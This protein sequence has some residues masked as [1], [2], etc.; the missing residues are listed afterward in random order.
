MCSTDA[1]RNWFIA[2]LVALG[3]AISSVILGI[4]YPLIA[5]ICFWAAVAW[6]AL[7]LTFTFAATSALDAFCACAAASEACTGLC[8]QLRSLFSAFI[9]FVFAGLGLAIWAATHPFA[10]WIAFA[11]TVAA[12]GA[13]GFA[14]AIISLLFSLGSCQS[15]STPPVP[16]PTG[17][18]GT[19]TAPNP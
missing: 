13:L 6:S 8:G 16:P 1:I 14:G 15:R 7:T 19:G 17:G 2:A 3:G 10:N 4:A 9:A 18:P 11:F 12:M 5:P